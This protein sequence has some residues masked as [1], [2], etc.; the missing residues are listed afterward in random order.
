[1]STQA[2][3]SNPIPII[4]I[5]GQMEGSFGPLRGHV[6]TGKDRCVGVRPKST[7]SALTSSTSA[8]LSL[9][10]PFSSPSLNLHP[11]LHPLLPPTLSLSLLYALWLSCGRSTRKVKS[12][13]NSGKND[14]KMGTGE[15]THGGGGARETSRFRQCARLSSRSGMHVLPT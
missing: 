8:P 7:T 4:Y 6:T 11:S 10:S 5:S 12:R 13:P 15:H 14:C 3:R 2:K 9:V 1:M